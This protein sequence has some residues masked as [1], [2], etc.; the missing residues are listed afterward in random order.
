[1]NG[2]KVEQALK[3][4]LEA[5]GQ[6]ILQNHSAFQSAVFDLLDDINYPDERLVLKYA[7]NSNS[8]WTLLGSAQVTAEGAKRAAEQ[9]QRESRMTKEDA[10]FVVRCAA[11][12]K[13]ANPN[14]VKIN[15]APKTDDGT[16][17]NAETKRRNENKCGAKTNVKEENRANAEGEIHARTA[18]PAAGIRSAGKEDIDA[19]DPLFA[20]ECSMPKGNK[21]NKGK[22]YFFRDCLKF[23]AYT[24]NAYGADIRP[25]DTI[26]LSY[27]A[28]KKLYSYKKGFWIA[29]LVVLLFAAIMLF[30]GAPVAYWVFVLAE[31]LMFIA[32][33]QFLFRKSIGL[34]TG[35][36]KNYVFAFAKRADKKQALSVLKGGL[37]T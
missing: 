11:A 36:I 18:P 35:I 33:F 27:N 23:E 5:K 31:G 7:M 34:K 9:M 29:Y 4:I 6:E 12:A 3:E 1:M 32:P 16:K 21:R 22:I 13:G 2:R 10:E 14:I 24:K 8:F 17:I 25:D 37:R 19:G 30:Y 28:I 20:A 15:T 26:K